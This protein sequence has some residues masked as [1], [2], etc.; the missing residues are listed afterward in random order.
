[1]N[2][3]SDEKAGEN[4]NETIRFYAEFRE[5][6]NIENPH[7]AP[8]LISTNNFHS[9]LYFPTFPIFFLLRSC[10]GDNSF[11]FLSLVV[12]RA[13]FTVV[14]HMTPRDAMVGSEG[15]G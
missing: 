13:V 10:H 3:I 4:E 14:L 8:G 11:A 2:V 7:G 9:D 15:K 1:M 5:W 12:C 6:I